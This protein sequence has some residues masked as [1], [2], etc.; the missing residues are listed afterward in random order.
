MIFSANCAASGG[1]DGNS[2]FLL[3]TNVILGF[4]GLNADDDKTIRELL[5]NFSYLPVTRQ[6]E[7]IAIA[8]RRQPK[9]LKLPDALILATANAHGLPLVTLDEDLAKL[10]VQFKPAGQ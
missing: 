9:K 1:N 8:L 5:D 10:F 3:D 4:P 7:D 2:F 6:I